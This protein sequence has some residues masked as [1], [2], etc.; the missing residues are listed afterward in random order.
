M[1]RTDRLDEELAASSL[2]VLS[3]RFE[4]LPMVM[5]EAMTHALPIVAFDC[6][7]GPRDVLT[8]GVDGLL[9]P[10]RDVDALAVALKEVV[11]DRRRRLEMGA[12]AA[13]AAH[14]YAPDVVMP[15]WENLF[16]ELLH[17]EQ[18]NA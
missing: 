1:G 4:G 6:P 5:I 13:A 10:P 8:D 17:G 11:S 12:A 7:T 18:V 2:Y 3:S 15:M 9:V 14:A 16:T